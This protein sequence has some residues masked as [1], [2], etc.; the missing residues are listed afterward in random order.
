MELKLGGLEL[1]YNENMSDSIIKSYPFSTIGDLSLIENRYKETTK[2][3]NISK[4]GSKSIIEKTVEM[5]STKLGKIAGTSEPQKPWK[6]AIPTPPIVGGNSINID[7]NEKTSPK[8]EKK[9]SEQIPQKHKTENDIETKD[10]TPKDGVQKPWRSHIPHSPN[11]FV[12][13]E[14]TST[15][16]EDAKNSS[17]KPWKDQI[18][19][20]NVGSSNKK[21]NKPWSNI[22]PNKK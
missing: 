22:I 10:S 15:P 1:V 9:W 16:K 19:S 13:C 21:E 4:D 5:I 12:V 3:T 6:V 8:E 18:V 2:T 14:G 7:P 20:Q 11:E 17:G